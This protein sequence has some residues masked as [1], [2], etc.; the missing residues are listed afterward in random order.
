SLLEQNYPQYEVIVINDGSTDESEDVLNRFRQ[1]Y[2]NLYHTFI[3]QESKYL[4]RRK[5]SLTLGIKAAQYEHLLFIEANCRPLT[6]DWIS[7]MV[8]H[9]DDATQIV[10][11]YCA[12]TTE[13]NFFH[14]LVAYDNL[15]TGL[16]YLSSA[17][18]GHPFSG[19]GRNLSY[20]KSLF[21]A[22]KGY[23][24]SL[25]L[26]AGDDDLFVN[27]AATPDN[28]KVEYAAEGITEMAPIEYF[29]VWKEGKV[30]RAAT[31]SH[32]KGRQRYFYRFD[33]ISCIGF[34]LSVIAAIAAGVCLDN[35]V[36]AA[37]AFL[38]YCGLYIIKA[39]VVKHASILLKQKAFSFLLPFLEAA[40][41]FMGAYVI[42]YRA[43]RGKR[44]Y[45]FTTNY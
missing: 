21:F 32:Y 20:R 3:P 23:S 43:F 31:R 11:G 1:K 41:L 10:V 22:R 27:E 44:D 14:K 7:T 25:T 35:P 42:V 33:A 12:Y 6:A 38:L 29:A 2:P 13:K 24:H 19:N 30:S 26:H 8:R 16:Q 40:R 15:M 18:V 39:R 4:S 5:L 37:V 28:T 45:T 9:Y 34:S 36:T 17:L